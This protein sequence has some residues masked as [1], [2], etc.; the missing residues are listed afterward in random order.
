MDFQ[1]TLSGELSSGIDDLM[2]Q[3]M[4]LSK[5]NTKRGKMLRKTLPQVAVAK[6]EQLGLISHAGEA[7]HEDAAEN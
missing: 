6:K 5:M 2:K 7:N 1:A 3:M 4:P